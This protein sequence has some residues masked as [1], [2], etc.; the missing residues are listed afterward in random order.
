[1]SKILSGG[2]GEIPAVHV[3]CPGDAWDNMIREVG[4]VWACE[5]FGYLPDSEFTKETIQTLLE[6]SRDARIGN[7]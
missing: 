6:R 2:P 3:N 5:W 1:M 7:D 4:V